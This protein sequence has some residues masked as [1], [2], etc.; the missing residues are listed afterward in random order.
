METPLPT[1]SVSSSHPCRLAD[2]ALQGQP[3]NQYLHQFYIL[4]TVS[5]AILQAFGIPDKRMGEEVGVW[6]KLEDG[7]SLGEEEFKEWCKGK[8]SG[9]REGRVV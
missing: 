8:V 1:L 9:V 6:I 7:E 2:P 5:S 3:S 4:I